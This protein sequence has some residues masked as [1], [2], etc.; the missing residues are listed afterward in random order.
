MAAISVNSFSEGAVIKRC[1]TA[2]SYG[3]LD[4]DLSNLQ[5]GYDSFMS[6]YL[7]IISG[8]DTLISYVI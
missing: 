3:N 1:P 5:N 2:S 4:I 8:Y 7:I 6:A